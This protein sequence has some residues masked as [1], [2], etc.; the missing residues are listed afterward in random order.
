MKLSSLI[1]DLH[2]FPGTRRKQAVGRVLKELGGAW[3]FGDVQ[4]GPGDDAAVLKTDSG[5]F[6][7]L[8][9]DSIMSSLV[10][11]DPYRAGRA[12]VLVNANDI[13]AMGGRPLALVNILAGVSPEQ[14]Q[15]ICR[16]MREEC[17]RL[18]VP[19][20]GGHVSPEGETPFLAAGIMGEAEAFLE[21][22]RALPGQVIILAMDLRGERWGE[23]LMN[24]DSHVNKD[25]EVLRHDLGILCSL[26]ED[27]L[28][29]SARDVSNAGILGSLAM[30][31][32]NAGLGGAVDLTRIKVPDPFSLS[33]WLKVYPS[34]GFLL[35]CD[36]QHS[37]TCLERFSKRGIWASEIGR[38]DDSHR[39]E[40]SFDN[41]QAVLFDFSKEG[42]LNLSK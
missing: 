41:E 29:S 5:R 40:L 24:W 11:A 8:A 37:D 38:T 1:E 31:L 27:A 17:C 16:G 2:K 19:M 6:L 4:V 21:D 33:D 12:V 36:K 25:P 13:Y 26:A 39:L 14:E 15:A 18:Q 28:C 34:Y 10:T 30:L 22:R 32:E 3:A 35:V 20:V 9:A 23:Y 7:F 42:I